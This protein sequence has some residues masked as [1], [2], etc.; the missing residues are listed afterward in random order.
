MYASTHG[1]IS[2]CVMVTE[3]L[4]FNPG[5]T[6]I[7]NGKVSI[8]LGTILQA[9]PQIEVNTKSLL[10]GSSNYTFEEIQFLLSKVPEV[11][12]LADCLEEK[13]K[14]SKLC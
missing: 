5:G 7:G 12:Q 6:K 10:Q 3:I 13:L 8:L 1:L 14:R 11:Q 2:S 9:I 4:F